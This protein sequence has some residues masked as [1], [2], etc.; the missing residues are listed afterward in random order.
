MKILDKRQHNKRNCP[1]KD[2]I[3]IWFSKSKEGEIKIRPIF[4]WT[5]CHLGTNSMIQ[6]DVNMRCGLQ[7][8]EIHRKI[9]EPSNKNN[10]EAEPLNY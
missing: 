8:D 7:L 9:L 3:E 1:I 5:E 10:D 4:L 6:V 2:I